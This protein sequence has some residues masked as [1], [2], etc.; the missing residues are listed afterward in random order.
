MQFQEKWYKSIFKT[1][2]YHIFWKHLRPC[3]C[4]SYLRTICFYAYRKQSLISKPKFTQIRI[5]LLYNELSET[6][7]AVKSNN[8]FVIWIPQ[9]WSLD[10]C[11]KKAFMC[12][13]IRYYIWQVGEESILNL[14]KFLCKFNDT[15]INKIALNILA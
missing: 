11:S 6:V 1:I 2:F 14:D 3:E 4:V 15:N 8:N 10:L 12:A 9:K 13:C 5:R 7:E